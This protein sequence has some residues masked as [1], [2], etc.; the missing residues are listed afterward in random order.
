MAKYD[1]DT[2]FYWL[3]LKED[4]FEDDAI[5]WLEE[6]KPNGR[7]YAYFYLKLCLKSLK[8]NGILIR[9]VGNILIPYDNEK[10]AEITKIDFDTVTVAMELLKKIGLIKIL[11]NGEIY[12]SQLEN[13]IGSKSLGAFKKQQQR[14]LNFGKVDN[15]R[16]LGGQVSTKDRDRT[17]DIVK[18]K[19]IDKDIVISKTTTTNKDI[20]NYIEESY[21]RTLAPIE[22]EK[23]KS[24]LLLFK[25]EMIKYAF[26]ISVIN[27]KKSFNY[28]E[29][30][31][32]NWK[33]ANYKTL[34][35]IKNSNKRN[36]E[37]ISEDLIN[38]INETLSVNWFEND[39]D[40]VE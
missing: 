38:E 10:L 19:D 7:D 6:Q 16:T 29:G 36:D 30:I 5:N 27:N 4:F 11:D 28:V 2:K 26:D 21:C 15:S 39:D 23:I 31:L 24:W 20:Y 33:S 34:E 37:E 8:T 25:E 14:Q 17:K 13:L 9:N 35:E 3:L 22:Y 12:L 18:D 32:N 40:D 1:K